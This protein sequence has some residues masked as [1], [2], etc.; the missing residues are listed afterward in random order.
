MIKY[1]Q[2]VVSFA[3]FAPSRLC[4]EVFRIITLMLDR[5]LSNELRIPKKGINIPS[6]GTKPIAAFKQSCATSLADA[7]FSSTQQRVLGLLFGQPERS[8]FATEIIG[9]AG[10]GTGAVQ[11]ELKK[12]SASGLVTLKR[13]GNQCHY[14]ANPASPLF[15]A[16]CDIVR[17]TSGLAEPL[18]SALLPFADR[19]RVA[20]VYGSVAAGADT[21]S[22]V[23]DVL[24][25]A[26][27]LTLEEAYT[28]LEPVE[29]QLARKISVTLY[30]PVEF[31]RRKAS[32]NA[33]V[34]KVLAGPMIP[35]LGGIHALA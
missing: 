32:G 20:S 34:T 28:A 5:S 4:G 24:L 31:L 13:I 29:R 8:F 23:I 10:S 16:L 1:D 9:L 22:S 21:A 33:F 3:I 6:M 18:R 2:P 35:L 27:A 15:S 30:T 14:Q 12:L 17:K 19:I 7:L 26:E 25:V 11:R